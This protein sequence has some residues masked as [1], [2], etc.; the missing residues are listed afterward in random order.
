LN[1]GKCLGACPEGRYFSKAFME[2]KDCVDNCAECI[3]YNECNKCD[4]GFLFLENSKCVKQC[5][6]GFSEDYL[7]KKCL[8]CGDNCNECD[9]DSLACNNCRKP[10]LYELGKCV[11]KCRLGFNENKEENI[12]ESK[13]HF[14]I[15]FFSLQKQIL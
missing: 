1:D 5:P 3:N 6:S 9:V 11:L 2:C 8:K 12:C 13:Y 4:E 10:F 15:L 7:N 14:K